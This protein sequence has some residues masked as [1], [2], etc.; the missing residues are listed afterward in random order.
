MS[1]P[2]V[3]LPLPSYFT[4]YEDL[5]AGSS[6]IRLTEKEITPGAK[7]EVKDLA[8]YNKD[9][10]GFSTNLLGHFLPEHSIY[11]P[12]K[13]AD[14]DYYQNWNEKSSPCLKPSQIKY[15]E[16]KRTPLFI[17]VTAVHNI[18]FPYKVTSK[19]KIK[20]IDE[21][22][23]KL[24]KEFKTTVSQGS[25]KV[26]HKPNLCNFWHF[27]LKVFDQNGLELLR[28][29]VKPLYER[30]AEGILTSIAKR[31]AQTLTPPFE[32]LPERYFTKTTPRKELFITR[33]LKK[34]RLIK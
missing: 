1:Y 34:L 8:A 16:V 9:L 17:P 14:L 18:S 13:K 3:L 5:P 19:E 23:G 31:H 6:L 26:V 30:A 10:F 22:T 27:E 20:F 4:I 25:V 21:K 15:E 2:K 28:K 24:R 32:P 11:Q 33:L 12:L 7:V 29:E